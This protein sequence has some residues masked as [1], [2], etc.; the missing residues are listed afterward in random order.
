MYYITLFWITT[1]ATGRGIAGLRAVGNDPCATATLLHGK[2][3]HVNVHAC[4]IPPSGRHQSG[5]RKLSIL[6]VAALSGLLE[7]LYSHCRVRRRAASEYVAINPACPNST[8][9]SLPPDGK[10]RF[11]KSVVA[12]SWLILKSNDDH[13]VLSKSAQMSQL[14]RPCFLDAVPFLLPRPSGLDTLPIS[15]I[16]TPKAFYESRLQ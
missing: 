8:S 11:P 3:E 16:T 4:R 15:G 1:H 10:S 7:L 5:M 9:I 12:K 14:N 13:G 2:I 6:I